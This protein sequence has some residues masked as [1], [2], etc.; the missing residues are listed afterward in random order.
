[1]YCPS[2][3]EHEDP[4]HLFSSAWKCPNCDATSTPFEWIAMDGDEEEPELIDDENDVDDEWDD[5]SDVDYG[6]TVYFDLDDEEPDEDDEPSTMELVDI[7]PL[8]DI[9]F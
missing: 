7:D 9:P 3:G 5:L 8:T 4:I 1:M 6:N 2:C